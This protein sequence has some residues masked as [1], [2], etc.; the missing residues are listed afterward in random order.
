VTVKGPSKSV[1]VTCLLCSMELYRRNYADH[2]KAKHPVEARR[3]GPSPSKPADERRAQ[4]QN[5]G[6]DWGGNSVNSWTV[7]MLIVKLVYFT[8]LPLMTVFGPYVRV[9]VPIAT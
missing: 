9:P 2:F 7:V 4:Q 5:A 3:L 6:E 1:R 8:F